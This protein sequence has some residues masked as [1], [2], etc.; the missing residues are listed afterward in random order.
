MR[1]HR[2]DGFTLIELI[3][4]IAVLGIVAAVSFPR[5]ATSRAPFAARGY[6]DEIAGA[7]KLARTV[8]ISSG[9]DCEV[10]FS[11]GPNGYQVMQRAENGTTNRCRD[12]GAFS[13]PVLR[14]DGSP[15][16]G[17]PPSEVR[18]TGNRT[19]VFTDEGRVQGA[20]PSPIV[21]TPFTVTVESGGW[22]QVQ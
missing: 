5:I 9:T 10:R 2:P 12:T 18:I 17:R 7:I 11:I 21:I 6:A 4:V 3:A 15:L 1:T 19:I 13:T 14:A 22:V 8:A 16:A 20:T